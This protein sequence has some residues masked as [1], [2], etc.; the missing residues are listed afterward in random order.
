[1]WSNN[2]YHK[3]G[4]SIDGFLSARGVIFRKDEATL[5]SLEGVT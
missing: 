4:V 5:K 2:A 1:M 3:I